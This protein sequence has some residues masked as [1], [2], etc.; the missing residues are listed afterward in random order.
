MA[1]TVELW[2]PF[3]E[4][5]RLALSIPV[6]VCQ[7]FSNHPLAWL[8]Y[9]GLALYGNEG[10]ISSALD[11]PEV[12]YSPAVIQAGPYYYVSQGE[13]FRRPKDPS[14]IFNIRGIFA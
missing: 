7:R 10:H 6:D 11:G 9:L 14:L 13:S 1:A 5:Y 3:G 8:R 2:M 4:E 12:D